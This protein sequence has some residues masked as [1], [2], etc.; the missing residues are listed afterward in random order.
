LFIVTAPV[1][2]FLISSQRCS[3]ASVVASK[4][5]TCALMR[6]AQRAGASRRQVIV[7]AADDVKVGI[8]GELL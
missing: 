1:F 6:R 2:Y 3:M 4:S 5:S 8:N 7:R